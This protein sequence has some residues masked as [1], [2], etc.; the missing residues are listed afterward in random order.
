MD[1]HLRDLRYFVAVAEELH[2]TKA[3]QRL[4]IAQPTLSRQIRQLESQLG[5][6]LFDRDQ[7]T[8][9]LTVAGR[10]LLIGAKQVLALW[11]AVT[12]ALTAAQDTLR[13]G[14]Q[15]S[16]G[17]GLLTEL[18]KASGQQ[19]EFHTAPWSDPTCGLATRKSDLALLWLPLPDRERYTS[20]ELR[21]EERW[22]LMPETHRLAESETV[23]FADI[24]D[25]TFIALPMDAGPLRDYWLATDARGGRKPVVGAEESTPEQTV[26]AVGLGLGI[27]ILAEDN[28]P[29]YRWPGITA[30]K[31]TGIDPCVLTLA[32]RV[33]DDRSSVL[34]FVEHAATS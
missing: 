2:F 30:R 12:E 33:D 19:L 5:V 16:I 21:T 18:E 10:E 25:E 11:G 29:L 7:R 26:E 23:D 22:V 4:D 13:V 17:R 34:D 8:V 24:V 27:C 32:W 14:L 3:A 6:S 1:P 9:A 15:D 28:L 20:R 31:L